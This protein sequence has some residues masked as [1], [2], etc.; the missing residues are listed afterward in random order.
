M[1]GVPE[2]APLPATVTPSGRPVADQEY[3]DV[4]PLRGIYTGTRSS[5]MFVEVELTA[6]R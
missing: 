3:G 5:A 4:P 2:T 6:L 1:V